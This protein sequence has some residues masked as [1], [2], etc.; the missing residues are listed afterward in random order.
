MAT[1]AFA[2]GDPRTQKIWSTLLFKDALDDMV[3]TSLMS[4]G[5]DNVL[6]VDKKLIA[7]PGN[8]IVTELRKRLTGA[9]KGDNGSIQGNE[10]ALQVLNQSTVIHERSTGVVSEGELSDKYTATDIRQDGRAALSEWLSDRL[11][12]DVIQALAGLYNESGIS[13]VNEVAPTTNRIWRG[14]QTAAGALAADSSMTLTDA[15]IG[16]GG[17]GDDLNYLFGTKV[18]NKIVEYAEYY[19]IPRVRIRN[20]KSNQLVGDYWVYVGHPFQFADMR[21]E[22]G[23]TGWARLVAQAHE[24]RNEHPLFTGAIGMWNG[25]VLLSS[26]KIP[27]RT[28][29]G[30]TTEAEG[31]TLA[32]GVTTD[33]LPSGVTA[34]RGLFLG[35]Q[36]G[37]L[38]WGRTPRW[39]EYY[40]DASS[41][42]T[43]RKPGIGT[44]MLYGVKKTKFN[45]HGETTSTQDDFSVICI[46][47]AVTGL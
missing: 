13:T 29:A 10:Q 26:N 34:A 9:G 14:G 5:G 45:D 3:L 11:E 44:D 25:V 30:G 32:A 42:K 19:K 31:F 7:K 12:Y 17:A 4:A 22:T 47:T 43:G 18:V 6:V 41:G 36:A 1:T 37:I 28:G 2:S 24:R 27:I 16:N 20:P 40:T 21:N 33:A 23:E 15:E 35:R 38:A 39:Y 46:D 8:T